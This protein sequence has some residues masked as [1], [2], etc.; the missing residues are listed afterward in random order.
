MR[1]LTCSWPVWLAALLGLLAG[2]Q[3]R[4]ASS[5]A[6]GG[7]PE[8]FAD[9]TD[10]VGLHFVHDAGPCDKYLL[11]ESMGSGAAVFDC[12]NDGKLAVYLV[13]NAG[14]NSASTNKLFVQDSSGHFVDVSQGSGLDVAGYGMGV[15]IGDVNNDGLPDV[16][17]TEFGRV[18]LF[19]NQG[20]HHFIDVTEQAGLNDPKWATAA[21][22]LDYDRDGWLDLVVINYCDNADAHGCY[23]MTGK[24]DY[25]GPKPFPGTIPRLYHNLGRQPDGNV[26]FEDVTAKS[27][28][29]SAAVKGLGVVCLDFNG[30]GWPDILVA[31]DEMPN[32]LWINQHD[33]TF[34]DEALSRGIALDATGELQANMGIALGDLYGT[35]RADVY[36][37]HLGREQNVLWCQT[38]PGMF[39]D[40]TPAAGLTGTKWRGTGFG[41]VMADFANQGTLDLVVANGRIDRAAHE[42]P[43]STVPP[44]WRP[45]AELNQ[46]F[47]GDRSGHFSDVSID[48]PTF[49]AVPGVWRG[50]AWADFDNDGGIDLLLTQIAGPAKIYRN[51]HPNRG[52]WLLVKAIDPALGGRDAYGA[53]V[54]LRAAGRSQVGWVNPGSSY[55]SSSDPRV[56]F[57]LGAATRFD[58]IEVQWPDGSH[59]SFPGGPVDQ[60]LKLPRG[61]GTRTP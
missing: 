23:D 31:N 49:C 2:C 19:L 53:R 28:L 12:D 44:H 26:R 24:L 43:Y 5:G 37:T 57:G 50:M 9:V 32:Q 21:A 20:H 10:Q 1:R 56:H 18:R 30:D 22:F 33:G 13:Q 16:L 60:V 59:E 4:D 17:L 11:K 34:K 14:P 42:L 45:Y 61:G 52:H 36:I 40:C 58:P 8:W 25:C 55:L 3:K 51:V 27:G 48:N 7:Q 35:G 6:S 47:A 15:A 39:E 29:A 38:S 54:T 46:V 41:T